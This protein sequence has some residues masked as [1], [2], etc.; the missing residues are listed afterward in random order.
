MDQHRDSLEAS[1]NAALPASGERRRGLLGKGIKLAVALPALLA[2]TQGGVAYADRGGPPWA[3]DDQDN[4]QGNDQGE[5]QGPGPGPGRGRGRGPFF[6]RP[7]FALNL[8]RVSV[9]GSS[10]FVP[11]GSSAGSDPLNF[12]VV[13]VFRASNPSSP[14]L[15]VWVR[16]SGAAPST[17]YTVAFARFNDHVRESLGTITTGPDGNFA[18]FTTTMLSGTN[19]VGSFVLSNNSNGSDQFVSCVP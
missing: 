3:G 15:P 9:V 6:R 10:D 11:S 7:F 8:C 16:L 17:S 19:R 2:A 5:D 12:G 18:G 4:D 13:R 14:A 1:E